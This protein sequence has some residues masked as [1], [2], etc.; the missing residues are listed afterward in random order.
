MLVFSLGMLRLFANIDQTKNMWMKEVTY[1]GRTEMMKQHVSLTR[2]LGQ[3]QLPIPIYVLKHID[4]TKN[5]C[6]TKLFLKDI[7][8]GG[9]L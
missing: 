2:N 4:H 9:D 7:S 3:R 1:E 6:I 5:M 8:L